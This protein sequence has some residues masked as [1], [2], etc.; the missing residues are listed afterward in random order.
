M[1][2]EN[3]ASFDK[4]LKTSHELLQTHDLDVLLEQILTELRN[5]VN[6]D[7]GSIYLVEGQALKFSYT[8]NATLQ[9]KLPF[10]KKLVYS[11]FNVKIDSKSIVGYVASTGLAVNV[12]NVYRIDNYQP[13]S[14][15][16]HFD[17]TTNYHTQSM[18]TVPIINSMEKTIGAIQLINA[19]GYNQ[20]IRSFDSIDESI[21]KIFAD[22]AAIAIEHAQMT[23]SMIMRI[24]KALELHDPEETMEHNNRI[25]AYTIEIY[26]NWARKKGIPE[27]EIN[28]KRDILRM[29]AM[30]HDIGKLLVPIEILQKKYNELTNEELIILKKSPIYSMK[31]FPD[32]YSS[33]DDMAQI[34]A[35]NYCENWDGSGYP[36]HINTESFLPLPGYEKADGNAFGK[37]GEEI[38]I[39]ARIVAVTA[40]Y[41]T[42]VCESTDSI[43]ATNAVNTIMAQSGKRFDPEVVS[44]FAN[45]LEMINS[46]SARYKNATPQVPT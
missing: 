26:E 10:G 12:A 41:D 4:I 33:F 5:A 46:I 39:Y 15:D 38:P 7:A 11:T 22:N 32:N 45:C 27:R 34:I 23:R 31:F 2:I 28:K 3:R 17:E 29:A 36:G 16:K 25:A 35:L 37:T 24:N 13:Y 9:K 44:A 30:L 21:V 40:A 6:C 43:T 19:I 14:F 1:E 18:L 8:Q 20:D 42:L